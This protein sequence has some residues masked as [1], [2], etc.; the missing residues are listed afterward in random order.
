MKI[1]K[2]LSTLDLF[3]M[4]EGTKYPIK[5]FSLYHSII[6]EVV[7]GKKMRPSGAHC[8]FQ[9]ML[10]PIFNPIPK[11]TAKS[12]FSN[13]ILFNLKK[14]TLSKPSSLFPSDWTPRQCV[15]TIIDIIQNNKN[16]EAKFDAKF[17]HKILINN[18]NNQNQIFKICLDTTTNTANFFP[19]ESTRKL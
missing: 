11:S 8:N 14:P 9:N 12:S 16:I 6:G 4:H 18:T 13:V 5:D 2:W 3:I 15:K 10:D 7:P 17:P 19:I 1:K